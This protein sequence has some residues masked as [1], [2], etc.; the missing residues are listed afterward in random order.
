MES[1]IPC[2]RAWIGPP[3]P[4]GL[5][6]IPSSNV[7]KLKDLRLQ[8]C[9]FTIMYLGQVH[10]LMVLFVFEKKGF[11]NGTKMLGFQKKV[12]TVPMWQSKENLFG[13]QRFF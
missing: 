4:C 9:T 11:W 10:R 3:T 7:S 12:V 1:F 8:L 2:P 6:W 13:I 5:T